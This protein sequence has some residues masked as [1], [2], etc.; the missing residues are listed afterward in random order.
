MAGVCDHCGG[1]LRQRED[2][3]PEAVR[4]RMEAYGRST[5][6]L[7]AFYRQ[8]GVLV[9]VSAEGAPE[10]IFQRTITALNGRR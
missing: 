2:D 7:V 9:S 1:R 4:V 8:R 3:R 6:P 10:E 5:A